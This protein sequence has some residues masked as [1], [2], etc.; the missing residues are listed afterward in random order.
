MIQKTVHCREIL[1]RT[2]IQ[3]QTVSKHPIDIVGV[4]DLPVGRAG[5]VTFYV[6]RNINSEVII[7]SDALE[8]GRAGINF[9]TKTLTWFGANGPCV[10]WSQVVS[11]DW[12]TL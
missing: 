12:E 1:R 11:L 2:N 8:Q 5:I 9:C 3:L 10:A 6:A 4:I 7:G